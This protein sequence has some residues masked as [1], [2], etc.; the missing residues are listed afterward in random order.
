MPS[1]RTANKLDRSSLAMVGAALLVIGLVAGLSFWQESQTHERRLREQGESLVRLL[2]AMPRDQLLPAQGSSPFQL[3]QH[4]DGAGELAY[5]TLVDPAGR[6]LLE[7]T[8]PG[9]FVPVSAMPEAPSAWLGERALRDAPSGRDILEFHAPVFQGADLSGFVRL[10][11]FAPGLGFDSRQVSFLATLAL[12]VFSL[13]PLFHLLLRREVQPLRRA[14]SEIASFIHEGR[15]QPV[16][17]HAAGEL[18]EFVGNFNRA[19]QL[20]QQRVQVLEHDQETLE[21]SAGC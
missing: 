8:A 10:G 15:L 17:V 2:A 3:L 6:A 16:A 4:G 21:T 5:A 18:A 19:M 14:S 12:L 1:T 9:L 20:A 7:V 13:V 11:Y